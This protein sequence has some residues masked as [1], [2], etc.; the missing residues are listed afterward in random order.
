M[1]LDWNRFSGLSDVAATFIS[2][3]SGRQNLTVR[4]RSRVICLSTRGQ[5]ELMLVQSENEATGCTGIRCGC[6]T[7]R[8]VSCLKW[9]W[10]R[11]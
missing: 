8:G 4:E 3:Q 10:K 6:H 11:K 1:A 9:L 5:V 2:P 7:K